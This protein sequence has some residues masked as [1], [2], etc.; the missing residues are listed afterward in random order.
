MESTTK[1]SVQK[2]LERIDQVWENIEDNIKDFS[3]IMFPPNERF[4][5]KL[6]ARRKIWM[7]NLICYDITTI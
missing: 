6:S 7:I 1:K 3:E 2:P 5:L 4:T